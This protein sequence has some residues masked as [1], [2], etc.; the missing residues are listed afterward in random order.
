[1]VSLELFAASR[2]IPIGGSP[3]TRS[4]EALVNREFVVPPKAVR[5]PNFPGYTMRARYV[6]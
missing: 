3:R 1:V 2:T 5:A 6:P 4:E